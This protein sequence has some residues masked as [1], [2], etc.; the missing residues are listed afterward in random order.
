[1]SQARYWAFTLNNP[2][3]SDQACLDSLMNEARYLVYQAET[4]AQ[5]T[6]HFQGYV[7]LVH[8]KRLAEIKRFLPRAHFSIA[9]GNA[10]QNRRYCSKCC[11]ACYESGK[12]GF[13]AEPDCPS[14]A[15]VEWPFEIGTM[16]GQGKRN[17]IHDFMDS[18]RNHVST[19]E[20]WAAHPSVLLRFKQGAT[21]AME[22]YRLPRS[23]PTIVFVF[24]GPPRLGKTRLAAMFPKSVFIPCSENRMWFDGLDPDEHETVIIDDFKPGGMSFTTMKRIMDRYPCKTEVKGGFVEFK[25]KYLVITSNWEPIKWYPKLFS[26]DMMHWTALRERIH[27]AFE[28]LPWP[29]SAVPPLPT[30]FALCQA[31]RVQENTL[32]FMY[33]SVCLVDPD[34]YAPTVWAPQ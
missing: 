32:D 5:G 26:K 2:E 28:F 33:S 23:E 1:M 7:Q 29:A 14:C 22:H 13:F 6:L 4:G 15:R 11:D 20:L 34:L 16:S 21:A 18:V 9:R 19:D 17:D 12:G 31:H 25:P 3:P 8:K 10:E 27:F 30:T 24:W